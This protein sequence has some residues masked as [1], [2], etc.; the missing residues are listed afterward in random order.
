MKQIPFA[1]SYKIDQHGNVF[2][3]L[4]RKMMKP[5]LIRNGYLR[6]RIKCDDG[7]ARSFLIHRLVA[8]TYIPQPEGKNEVN[9]VD[10]VK[11]NNH[12]SNLEW[13][14]RSENQQHAFALGL[15]TNHGTGNGRSVLSES[16]V[17]EIYW[18]LYNGA[19]NSDVCREYGMS[20]SA[21]MEIKSKTN[22]THLTKD[23]PDIPVKSKSDRLSE[24]TV[25]WICQMIEKGVGPKEIY[26]LCT[27]KCVK[28]DHIYD[29]KRRRGFRHISCNYVW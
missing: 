19:R 20:T 24:K 21:I 22:W 18:K 10:G 14:T 28:L 26:D 5:N 29:I 11:T 6:V 3:S 2:S 9:H 1:K 25:I 17:I 15:N 16:D 13:V 27:N 23:L 8:L 4:T 12:L 7:V